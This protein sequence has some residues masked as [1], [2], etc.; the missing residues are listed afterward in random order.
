MM[1]EVHA[2]EADRAIEWDISEVGVRQGGCTHRSR[3]LDVSLDGRPELPQAVQSAI[4]TLKRLGSGWSNFPR[5]D[6]PQRE[7]AMEQNVRKDQSSENAPAPTGYS[8]GKRGAPSQLSEDGFIGERQMLSDLT[9]RPL[10][11]GDRPHPPW[12]IH[13]GSALQEGRECL[14]M[15]LKRS[16]PARVRYALPR[17][18]RRCRRRTHCRSIG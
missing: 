5:R 4:S 3:R 17:C 12:H 11:R 10:V 15:L 9:W 13:G 2:A 1:I 18:L 8:G 6:G 14:P 16:R 7:A